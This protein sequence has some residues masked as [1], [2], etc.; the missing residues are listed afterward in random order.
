VKASINNALL[1]RPETTGE[2][3]AGILTNGMAAGVR[4]SG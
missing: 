3:H 2:H 4:N 1:G